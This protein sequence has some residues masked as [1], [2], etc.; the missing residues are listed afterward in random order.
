MQE[1]ASDPTRA[2]RAEQRRGDPR[3]GGPVCSPLVCGGH[4]VSS[5]C[6]KG[7]SSPP[8][9][10]GLPLPLGS[11]KPHSCSWLEWILSKERT[12]VGSCGR[13][14]AVIGERVTARHHEVRSVSRPHHP[15]GGASRP[16]QPREPLREPLALAPRGCPLGTV[17][18]QGRGAPACPLTCSL[19]GAGFGFFPLKPA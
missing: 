17:S 10:S 12:D 16:G 4:P 9:L 8:R 19:R 1:G 15:P 6:W 18:L 5:R 3:R 13:T 11:K 7:K 14:P 2:P